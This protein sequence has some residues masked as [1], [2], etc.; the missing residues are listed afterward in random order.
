MKKITIGVICALCFSMQAQA[1]FYPKDTLSLNI[2]TIESE[3]GNSEMIYGLSIFQAN[4]K[5]KF[6]WAGGIDYLK[7][8]RVIDLP[9]GFEAES[10]EAKE[11]I[12]IPSLGFSYGITN[13]LYIV[14]TAG[15]TMSTAQASYTYT[16]DETDEEVEEE[17]SDTAYGLNA[18][19][20]LMYKAQNG[21]VFGIGGRYSNI[22]GQKLTQYQAKIGFS[23]K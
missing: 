11:I 14:P 18:G 21:F 15:F 10:I 5:G 4:G 16:D 22:D 12:L 9:S 23:F 20:D 7:Y 19:L 6:G 13:G 17:L 2:G 1:K 8:K 3:N